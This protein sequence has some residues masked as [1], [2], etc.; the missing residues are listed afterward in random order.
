[1]G[2]RR[3]A[4]AV[5]NREVLTL[6]LD[7]VPPGGTADVLRRLEGLGCGY[8]VYST[9]KHHEAAPPAAR[10]TAVGPELHG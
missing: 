3:K 10:T 8:C 7:N 5:V 6:D 2:N 4:G 1:M 9:R